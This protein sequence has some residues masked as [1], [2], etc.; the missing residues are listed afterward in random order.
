MKPSMGPRPALAT[1]ACVLVMAIGIAAGIGSRITGADPPSETPAR[2]EYNPKGE[3]ITPKGFRSWVFVGAD[4]SPVY[5]ADLKESTPRE[6]AR[7]EGKKPDT[8]HN[9]YINREAY[10]AFLETKTFPDPTILVMEVFQ[11]ESKDPKGIL[12]SGEFENKR[13]GFEVAV[14]DKN[15][16][17][18]GVP[19]AYY[20]FDFDS[21]GKPTKPAPAMPD[22]AC[23]QCHLRHASVD[24]VWVQFYPGLRDPE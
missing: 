15:R 23:Y 7:N 6:R 21:Q 22:A 24:N 4:L 16:P 2:P 19:W 17:G 11:A 3:L 5:G 10:R 9:I 8:F 1:M 20:A 18:G 13:I 12:T 14:K